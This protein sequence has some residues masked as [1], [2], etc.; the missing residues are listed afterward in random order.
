MEIPLQITVRHM[1]HSGALDAKIREKVAGLERFHDRIIGCR[2][3]VTESQTQRQEGR[4]FEVTV[5][6]RMPGRAEVVSNRSHS[7][8]VYIALHEAIDA[9]TRQIEDVVRERR[10]KRRR[11]KSAAGNGSDRG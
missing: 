3:V 6:V 2:V 7:E 1:V 11:G 5:D 9:I 4:R 10:D 8:D